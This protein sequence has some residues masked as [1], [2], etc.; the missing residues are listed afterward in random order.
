VDIPQEYQHFKLV[1]QQDLTSAEDWLF[2]EW[3]R[4]A[5]WMPFP[6]RVALDFVIPST[7]KFTGNVNLAAQPG[8]MQVLDQGSLGSCVD[9]AVAGCLYWDAVKEGDPK[10]ALRS[11]L[12]LYWNARGG[13]PDDSGSTLRES[14]DG[15]NTYGACSEAVWPYD[16][17]Q[18]AVKPPAPAWADALLHKDSGYYRLL[19]LNDMRACLDQGYP[20]AICMGVFDH[21]Y[22]LNGVDYLLTIPL[23]SETF[24]GGHCVLVVGYDDKRKVFLVQNSWG[25]TWGNKGFFEMTYA[26]MADPLYVWDAWTVRTIAAP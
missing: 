7:L 6:L 16:V 20:F 1:A 26:L 11:R 21:F 18:F 2:K 17:S 8:W 5:S 15:A 10:P 13:S 12:F 3:W 14:L 22:A 9:N 4:F 19:D 23:S 25:T 24:H